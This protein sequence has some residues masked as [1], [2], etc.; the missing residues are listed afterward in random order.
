[1]SDP[2][3]PACDSTYLQGIAKYRSFHVN[4]A[5]KLLKCLNCSLVFADPMPTTSFLSNYNAN[6]FKIAHNIDINGQSNIAMNSLAR[7]RFEYLRD[8]FLHN[9][10]DAPNILEIGPGFGYLAREIISYLPSSSYAAIESDTQASCLLT[11]LGINIL[12]FDLLSKSTHDYDLIII[13]HVLEHIPDPRLF[14]NLLRDKLS[15]RGHIFIDIPCRDYLYKQIDEPHVLFFDKRSLSYLL[16][17]N[18]LIIKNLDYFGPNIPVRSLGRPLYYFKGIVRRLYAKLYEKLP[19]F[20]P[21]LNSLFNHPA[22]TTSFLIL[23]MPTKRSY[24]PS[25]WIRCICYK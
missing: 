15:F 14:I 16:T 1:M 8:N 24:K 2:K 5:N 9:F 12:T 3:C 6:Y 23:T 25:W 19:A 4:F 11:S 13:S 10:S 7:I 20:Q 18:G 22:N 17:S 21:F